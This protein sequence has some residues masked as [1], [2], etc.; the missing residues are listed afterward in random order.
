VAAVTLVETPT[1]EEIAAALLKQTNRK[2]EA[3][4]AVENLGVNEGTKIS[5]DIPRIIRHVL[6][7]GRKNNIKFIFD[8]IPPDKVIVVRVQP[9]EKTANENA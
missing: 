5:G 8:E 4:R 3:V 2:S 9:E 1:P 7:Y 6:A